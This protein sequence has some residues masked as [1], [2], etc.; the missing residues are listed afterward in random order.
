M[1]QPWVRAGNHTGSEAQGGVCARVT[2][3]IQGSCS[4]W[5][6]GHFSEVPLKCGKVEE[7]SARRVVERSLSYPYSVV[8][9]SSGPVTYLIIFIIFLL[10]TGWTF[11]LI[12]FETR[13]EYRL[14]KVTVFKDFIFIIVLSFNTP[15]S[16]G[17]NNI[18]GLFDYCCTWNKW[19]Y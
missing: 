18:A 16:S 2:G 3:A 13:Q 4:R 19:F 1:R 5:V 17:L 10:S 15:N 7:M 6:P 8:S 9:P 14:F 12:L 11:F